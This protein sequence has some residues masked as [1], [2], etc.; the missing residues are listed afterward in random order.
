MHLL[1][2][3]WIE[4]ADL[5]VM[6]Q[7]SVSASFCLGNCTRIDGF[8]EKQKS[9]VSMGLS[10]R[11]DKEKKTK[12]NVYPKRSPCVALILQVTFA[13]MQS[14]SLILGYY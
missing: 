1:R 13:F 12:K 5:G 2:E 6:G 3:A 8:G 4:A 9:L 11:S 7:E 10:L 14:I